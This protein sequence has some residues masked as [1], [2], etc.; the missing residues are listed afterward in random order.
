M[1]D[2][3]SANAGE[4]RIAQHKLELVTDFEH[5]GMEKDE[6]EARRWNMQ[7]WIHQKEINKRLMSLIEQLQGK[8]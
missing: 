5:I 7:A 8:G 1:I 3:W 2:K 4:F 6:G